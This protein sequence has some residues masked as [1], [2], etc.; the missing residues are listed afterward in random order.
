MLNSS[1][2]KRNL[3]PI[4]IDEYREKFLFPIK[5][6]YESVGFDFSKEPFEITN[7]EFHSGFEKNFKK[8]ALQPDALSTI[9]KLKKK[10]ITQS[11]LS[12]TIQRKLNNQV[13]YFGLDSFLDNIVGLSNTPSGFGKEY[14]GR[15][16][17]LN[18]LIPSEETIIVG[19]SMLDYNVSQSLNISCALIYNGHNNMK[20]LAATGSKTFPNIR[21]FYD[22]ITN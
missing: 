8:L 11:I 18:V 13:K 6:F 12:A 4:S 2:E 5:T 3:K 15:E 10:G 22:W 16:L 1:L 14:E 17:L 7:E 20:R 19:D 9:K 21:S